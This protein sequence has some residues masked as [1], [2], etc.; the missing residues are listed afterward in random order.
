MENKNL[1]LKIPYPYF[2]LNLARTTS[3]GAAMFK[4]NLRKKPDLT[5]VK[6]AHTGIRLVENLVTILV[7]S[8]S[9]NT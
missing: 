1:E 2:D 8:C 7:L 3:Y 6:I 4:K 5:F 9:N